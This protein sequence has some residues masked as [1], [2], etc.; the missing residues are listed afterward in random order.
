ML[1]CVRGVTVRLTSV[2]LCLVV[3]PTVC[4]RWV[5]TLQLV[6]PCVVIVMASVLWLQQIA[7]CCGMIRVRCLNL[8][9]V[10][11]SSLERCNNLWCA[12]R[13]GCCRRLG[14]P[15]KRV[16]VAFGGLLMLGVLGVGV[17]GVG[18]LRLVLTVRRPLWTIPSGRQRPPRM[19]RTQRS[20]PML[21]LEQ[22]WQFDGVCLGE[23]RFL[24]LRNSTPETDM[25]GKLLPRIPRIRLTS[26]ASG[27]THLCLAGVIRQMSWN[28]LTRILLLL[29]SVI[30]LLTRA[31]PMQALP[32]SPRLV[33]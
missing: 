6:S 9:R 20:C 33:S 7:F 19:L 32:R 8:L 21:R 11:L 25:L 1:C 27:G 22:C 24:F 2:V 18:G 10:A 12:T 4:R 17:R 3:R 13:T 5:L 16:V 28:P 26:C 29:C 14:W 23:T 31:W 30:L 15:F